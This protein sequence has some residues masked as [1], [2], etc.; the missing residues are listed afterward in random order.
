MSDTPTEVH[1][2]NL[3]ADGTRNSYS[4]SCAPTGQRMSYAACLW[5]Q[6]VLAGKD[7][8]TPADW[9][10]CRQAKNACTCTALNMRQEEL[11][12]G[13]SIYFR[14]RVRAPVQSPVRKWSE[15]PW[16]A[17]LVKGGAVKPAAVPARKPSEKPSDMFD[18]MDKLG[19][20]S[21]AINANVEPVQPVVTTPVVT[22]PVEVAPP[23]PTPSPRLTGV[24]SAMPGESPLQM[25]RRLAA[26]KSALAN[27]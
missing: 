25:A 19:T 20:Y 8:K 14:D 12:K 4:L 11:L 6:G 17:A 2:I 3:S 18:S 27:S 23:Q 9:E 7:I 10:A 5:R 16:N 13:H 15:S 22:T 24:I 26:A 1:S 21:D